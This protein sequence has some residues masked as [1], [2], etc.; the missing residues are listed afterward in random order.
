MKQFIKFFIALAAMTVSTT[1][2]LGET[3]AVEYLWYNKDISA[4]DSNTQSATKLTSETTSLSG[5]CY[6]EG[7]VTINGTVTLTGGTRIILCDGAT[8]TINA[9][10]GKGIDLNGKYLNIYGQSSGIHAG[11]LFI[12]SGSEGISGANDV[13]I[14][15]GIIN[16]TSTSSH[17]IYCNKFTLNCGKVTAIASAA[18]M[19][20]LHADGDV[21]IRGGTLYVTGGRYGIFSSDGKDVTI[22]SGQVTATGGTYGINSGG[23]INLGW[24]NA[25]DY[26]EASSYNKLPTAVSDKVF[27][28]SGYLK[29]GGSAVVDKESLAGKRLT[30][31][32]LDALYLLF[33]GAGLS[34]DNVSFDRTIAFAGERVAV[35]VTPPAG[36]IL[37]S[38]TYN[39]GTTDHALATQ[40]NDYV[41]TMPDEDVTVNATFVTPVA[42]IGDTKYATLAA[43]LAAVNDGETITILSD[44]D[45]SGTNYSFGGYSDTRSITIDMNS[46]TVSF[47]NIIDKFGDL[48]ITDKTTAHNGV[49]NLGTLYSQGNTIIKDVTLNCD[50][51][52][53][54][55][56][57]DHTLTF[58]NAKVVCSITGLQWMSSS[59]N[60]VL[61]NGADVEVHNTFWLG[62]DDYNTFSMTGESTILKL[63]N[64]TFSGY[65]DLS[66]KVRPYV[67]PSLRSDFAFGASYGTASDPY[68]LRSTWGLALDHSFGSNATVKFYD[69]GL[70]DYDTDNKPT[71]LPNPATFNPTAYP[72]ANAIEEI[73]NSDSKDRYIIVHVVPAAGNWTD[74][75]QLMAYEVIP[76]SAL[77]RG[78]DIDPPRRPTL[79]KKDTYTYL[80]INAEE[81]T[82]DRHDGAGWYY[83]VLPGTH[84]VSAK[85]TAS[86]VDGI[87]PKLFGFSTDDEDV[88]IAQDFDNKTITLSRT[89]DNWTAELTY[90][91]FK[92]AFDGSFG[93]MPKVVKIVVKNNGTAV[94]TITDADVIASMIDHNY[95]AGILHL[96]N[97]PLKPG[98]IGYGL[99]T[100]RDDNDK[101]YFIVDLPF[102]PLDPNDAVN[103]PG[104]EENPWL[105]RNANELNL[106]AKCVN[107]AE[108]NAQHEYLRQT[109]DID[110]S[111]ID[112]F[113]P[114]GFTNGTSGF[115]GNYDGY[116]KTISDIN[117][118][119][120]LEDIGGDGLIAYVGLFGNIHGLSDGGGSVKNVTL[121][122]CSFKATATSCATAVGGIAGLATGGAN[123]SMN[124]TDC[125]VLGNS[126]IEGLPANCF[127]G[128]I[129]GNYSPTTNK[130]ENNY[131]GFDVTVTN[132]S[133]SL[134]GYTK[135]GTCIGTY[136]MGTAS[137]SYAWND[138]TTDNGAMLWVKKATVPSENANGSKV[139]FNEVTK[140]TDRYDHGDDDFYYAVGQPITLKV[141][142]GTSS[143]GDIRTFYDQL[144]TL[145]MNDGTS[146][147]DIKTTLGFTMPAAD[148]TVA[149]T[150]TPSDWFTI[151][152][153][154]KQYMSFYHE[155]EAT[156][157]ANYTISDGD[158]TGKTVKAM[159]VSS[160]D[161]EKGDFTT[162]PLTE[163]VGNGVTRHISYSGVPTLFCC[164]KADGSNDVL[165]ALLRFD[166][167]STARNTAKI[168]DEFKGIA[169]ATGLSGDGIYMMNGEGDF[170]RVF[171]T[172]TDNTL[173]AHHCYIN[174]NGEA[175]HARLHNA[176]ETN[177]ISASTIDIASEGS[178][179]TLDGRKLNGK[180]TRKGIYIYNGK[181]IAIK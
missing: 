35:T 26:I 9:S 53:N 18:T 37:A 165:P 1:S 181:K 89:T 145:T 151:P 21:T 130:L 146:D 162:T 118:T 63:I 100:R 172:D 22:N 10:S 113:E 3:K 109:D 105:I 91:K 88:R 179:Y 133:A 47:G 92:W 140:G 5:Y 71:N 2:A 32:M 126:I 129:V 125:K 61:K 149:A 123:N 158:G 48:T 81:Q 44:K 28:F 65:V 36:K 112:N 115:F 78:I 136:D 93:T 17:G 169:T 178:W 25:L 27:V 31:T 4:F 132:P 73:N 86:L 56:G 139:E 163:D 120:T 134:S 137:W 152:S 171:L 159:T 160:V 153:N 99:F 154:G 24:T 59:G 19:D 84:N 164:P 40:A 114:I 79:L 128:A 75:S 157:P 6:V 94:L 39:D 51:I 55:G 14:H 106:L 46:Y 131:Y 45:E 69:G 67:K 23:A 13:T 29:F 141:T 90:D 33:L 60:V 143:D 83:Y 16:I 85:Y 108:W 111:T 124:I 72:V 156:A 82:A 150:F 34:S 175:A 80:D 148:A 38:I 104:S 50:H 180:P 138:V 70:V 20:G 170:I 41:F 76:A 161:I 135:R 142:T 110:M 52:N 74:A 96:G 15:G 49:F 68:V 168:A 30:P 62:Y 155:W 107:V 174:L 11:L 176:G 87:A 166:P 42:Q 101:T 102:V 57:T 117:F 7:D 121:M 12:N 43:A 144:S 98:A 64:C 77:T 167:N 58:D 103:H 8:L 97:L 173:A 95:G 177:S 127:S 116:G 147:T 119:C 66:D 122:D 54:A